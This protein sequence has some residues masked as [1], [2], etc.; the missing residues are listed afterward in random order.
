MNF[1]VKL[2]EIIDYA[3]G[4]SHSHSYSNR[5]LKSSESESKSQSPQSPQSPPQQQQSQQ[6]Q[7]QHQQTLQQ[8]QQY[9]PDFI[10]TEDWSGLNTGVTSPWTESFLTTA[11]AQKQLMDRYSSTGISH[12]FLYEQRAFHYLTQSDIWTKRKLPKYTEGNTTEIRSHFLILPQCV[13]NS[14]SVHAL[15]TRGDRETTQYI[16]GDF[17]IHFAG[18]KG[19]LKADLMHHYLQLNE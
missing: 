17:I 4:D 2:E 15:E 12:P 11:Y 18:K 8:T 10:M 1:S 14:Y 9:H 16:N 19:E 13:M 6:S 5:Y 3:N 7:Q